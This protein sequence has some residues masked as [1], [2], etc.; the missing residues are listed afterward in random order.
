MGGANEK[1]GIRRVPAELVD[2]LGVAL[3][4]QGEAPLG[5]LRIPHPDCLVGGARGKARAGDVPC[6]RSHTVLVA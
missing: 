6:H 3:E 2:G 4:L 1:V 5:F